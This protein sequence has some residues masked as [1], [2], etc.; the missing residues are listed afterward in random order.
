MSDKV[1]LAGV[2]KWLIGVGVVGGVGLAI[3][4]GVMANRLD[5]VEENQKT[6]QPTI[7]SIAV[8]KG[9]VTNIKDNMKE[10]KGDMKS[11]LAELRAR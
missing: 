6:N 2:V 3:T 5:T 1:D 11:I 4:Q 10:M 7:N 8:I 9:D